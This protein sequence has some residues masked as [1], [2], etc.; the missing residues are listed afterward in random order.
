MTDAAQ[1]HQALE[2]HLWDML[3]AKGVGLLALTRSGLHPQ[4]TIVSVDRRR[5]VLWLLV[6]RDTDLVRSLGEGGAAIFI[7]QGR[8][9]LAS[10]SGNLAERFDARRIARLW[11][12]AAAAW[13][14]QGP[15]DRA[16]TLLRME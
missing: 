14:P 12:P 10:I 2:S 16:L 6:L 9:L 13:R 7:A 3:E 15:G 8:G 5:R 4:P 11:T 1:R